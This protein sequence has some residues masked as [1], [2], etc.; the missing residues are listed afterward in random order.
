MRKKGALGPTYLVVIILAVLVL[1]SVAIVFTGGWSSLTQKVKDIFGGTTAGTEYNLAIK[2]CNTYC[3]QA[4]DMTDTQKKN[5][6]YCTKE[7]H[8]DIDTDG[9]LEVYDGPAIDEAE[10]SRAVKT[11]DYKEFACS[12]THDWDDIPT[13]LQSDLGVPCPEV[14]AC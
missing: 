11:G 3:G 4:S 9:S 13:A 12:A 14:S 5:S 10:G 2:N 6:A 7:F 1:V 8:V